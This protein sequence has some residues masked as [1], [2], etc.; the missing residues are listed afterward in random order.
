METDKLKLLLV[1][2][3]A[4]QRQLI[5][6]TLED[7]FGP[8]TVEA[9]EGIGAALAKDLS[10]F[11]LILTDYNLTDGTG[12]DL[13]IQVR[14]RCRTPVILVTGENVARIATEAVRNGATDYVVKFGDYLFTIPL[15]VEKNLAV[16]KMESENQRLRTELE[17]ALRDVRDKNVALE[18][19]LRKVEELAATDPLTGLYN[20]RQF[21]RV[22]EQLYSESERV[23]ADLSCVMIDL[24][25]YKQLNDAYG[26]ALGDQL[27]VVAGKVIQANLRKMDVAARY[28][29][30]EFVM[31]LPHATVAEAEGVS[32][33]IREQY[34]QGSAIVLRRNEGVN[35]SIGVASRQ[36]GSPSH[37]EQ[38]VVLADAA[39]YR[40]KALGKAHITPREPAGI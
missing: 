11:S 6:E 30:D 19:S 35:M 24:D 28:G 2:D 13:L 36:T 26:H 37:G 21:G 23:G 18:Q 34:R 33:R 8:G 29:G 20:R 12:M 15:I 14:R 4:D 22:L 39:M 27:L 16:A 31:L 9:V 5:R 7:R 3:D 17:Q 10:K 32:Q 25:G 1:E 40:A 38:L